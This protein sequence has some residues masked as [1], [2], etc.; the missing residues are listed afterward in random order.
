MWVRP[1]RRDGDGLSVKLDN[2]HDEKNNF[3][4]QSAGSSGEEWVWRC[5]GMDIFLNLPLGKWTH[6]I[7]VADGERGV[8]RTYTNNIK[9][10]EAKKDTNFEFGSTSLTIG[11]LAKVNERYFKGGIDEV[12]ILDKAI[13]KL[14]LTR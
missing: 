14:F 2:G 3:G 1:E 4:I 12:V 11:K 7:V 13:D 9:V 6:F 8:I 10:G 5:N